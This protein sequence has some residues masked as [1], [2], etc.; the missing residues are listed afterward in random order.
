MRRKKTSRRKNADWPSNVPKE[1]DRFDR[2]CR[3][4]L[5]DARQ[6][7]RSLPRLVGV[8]LVPRGVAENKSPG[9]STISNARLT[10][11]SCW[12]VVG[13]KPKKLECKFELPDEIEN[14]AGG[15]VADVHD[16][17]DDG[18]RRS[19]AV[20]WLS[21]MRVA[22]SNTGVPSASPTA[23][24]KNAARQARATESSSSP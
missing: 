7:E 14:I 8:P 17:V 18:K 16:H 5:R 13:S 4:G 22:A 23:S 6:N 11:N 2:T 19:I 21:N 1:P 15:E 3:T 9:K 10:R 12:C 24:G 20:A